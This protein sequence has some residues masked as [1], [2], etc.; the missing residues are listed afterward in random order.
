MNTLPDL[1]V[2]HI[3]TKPNLLQKIEALLALRK[4]WTIQD[5]EDAY[6]DDYEN[7][8]WKVNRPQTLN[9]WRQYQYDLLHNTYDEELID[10]CLE[11]EVFEARYLL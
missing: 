6:S 8:P 5:F 7:D 2:P 9:E 1:P 11:N 4:S 3:P 10:E